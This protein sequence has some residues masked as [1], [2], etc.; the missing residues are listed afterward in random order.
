V[1]DEEPQVED[2]APDESVARRKLPLVVL[3]GGGVLLIVIIAA[4]VGFL[5]FGEKKPP[6]APKTKTDS[7]ASTMDF[8]GHID[9]ADENAQRAAALARQAAEG[10]ISRAANTPD[11]GSP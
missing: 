7:A 5:V 10:D 6:P 11:P 8:G 3:I 9:N 1:S 2:G 4:V